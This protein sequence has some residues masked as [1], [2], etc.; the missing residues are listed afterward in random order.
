[1]ASS[2]FKIKVGLDSTAAERGLANIGRSAKKL[3]RSMGRLAGKGLKLGAGLAVASG[4]MAVF[5]GIKF[6][7]DSSKAAADYEKMGLGF[8][9][10]LGSAEK[11]AER[12]RAI[13]KMSMAT[14][15]EP[16]E[17]AAAS[18]KLQ[19]LGGDTAAIGEGLEMVGD[20]AAM[21]GE[22]LD[23]IARNVGLLFQ[24]L[25]AGGEVGEATNMLQQTVKG[26]AAV[27]GEI[28][29]TVA[30]M[31]KGDRAFMSS[32]EALKLIQKGFVETKGGMADL[33]NSFGGKASTMLGHLDLLR[34]AF[35]TGINRGLAEGLD[36]MNTK[37]P[38]WMEA[39]KALGD[40]IGLGIAEAIKG[41]SKL[42]EMQIAFLFQ[43]L[44]QI[45]GAVFMQGL[46]GVIRSA[47][48]DLIEKVIDHPAMKPFRRLPG[49]AAAQEI[50]HRPA[51]E[52]MRG[53]PQ[54][55]IEQLI[56][57]AGEVLGVTETAAKLDALLKETKMT[58]FILS[59]TSMK[60]DKEGAVN[61][62]Y[63]SLVYIK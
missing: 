19:A 61:A 28:T 15:F 22:S 3:N 33:A 37:L 60:H 4:A 2:G 56:E 31:R 1:M 10:F 9:G 43:K 32:A 62:V 21:T 63:E 16:K 40:A 59:N 5:A 57:S 29:D 35:G 20:A 25:T 48:P 17:L 47:L 18:K 54:L 46:G 6:I 41:N 39:S 45:G 11:A 53:T 49:V 34:I 13:E 42:M 7:K 14:P 8:K 30:A 36:A 55:P 24:G 23:V 58:N 12:M 38:E 50:I 52:Y 51:A 27:K 26:F 44:A